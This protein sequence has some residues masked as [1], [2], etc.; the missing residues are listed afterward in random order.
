M[1]PRQGVRA[2]QREP[3]LEE[4]AQVVSGAN[5]QPF[6]PPLRQSPEQ[7]LPEAPPLLDLAEDRLHSGHAQGI[8]NHS[9]H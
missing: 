2:G 8:P 4:L 1:P 6:P 9:W 7:E 5:K 3:K